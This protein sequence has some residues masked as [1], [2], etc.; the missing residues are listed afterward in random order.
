M[1]IFC[2]FDVSDP[3]LMEMVGLFDKLGDAA[4]EAETLL[5]GKPENSYKVMKIVDVEAG[6]WEGSHGAQILAAD[7]H[8]P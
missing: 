5:F 7:A 1:K 3:C 2:I 6:D 8:K 4:D